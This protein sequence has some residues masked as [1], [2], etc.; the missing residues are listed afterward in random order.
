MKRTVLIA[1]PGM[2]LTDGEI[3]GTKIFLEEGRS[4]KKFREI[5]LEEYEKMMEQEV[6]AYGGTEV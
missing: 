4:E 2:I 5:P 1:S 6:T 3:Y